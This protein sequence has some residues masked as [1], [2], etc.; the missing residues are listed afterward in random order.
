FA[1]QVVGDEHALG[2]RVRPVA[3]A[4]SEAGPWYEIVGI[5]PDL[6][7][8]TSQG[9]MYVPALPGA[10]GPAGTIHLALHAGADPAAMSRRIHEIGTSLDPALR[11]DDVRRLDEI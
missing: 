8:N 7:A 3:A 2:R 5:V 10:R 6:P 4:G 1:R 9:R 11:L